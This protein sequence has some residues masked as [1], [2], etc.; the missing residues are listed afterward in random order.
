MD[1]GDG[2]APVESDRI[3]AAVSEVLTNPEYA[4]A[5]RRF[6]EVLATEAR[7]RPSAADEAEGLLTTGPSDRG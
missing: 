1:G 7:T 3:A 6:A 4:D 5:A 2:S